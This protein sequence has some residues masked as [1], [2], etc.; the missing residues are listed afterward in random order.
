MHAWRTDV[1]SHLFQPACR[2]DCLVSVQRAWVCHGW[3]RAG[4]YCIP[5]RQQLRHSVASLSQRAITACLL[6]WRSW[7][8][9]LKSTAGAFFIFCALTILLALASQVRYSVGSLSSCS[10]CEPPLPLRTWPSAVSPCAAPACAA[11]PCCRRWA[12]LS[13]LPAPPRRWHLRWPLA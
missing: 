11:L 13:R 4:W 7:I 2:R 12:W 9:G 1:F 8:V 10:V 6:T 3:F 5:L